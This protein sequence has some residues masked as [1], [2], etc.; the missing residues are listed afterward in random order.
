MSRE[1]EII[2]ASINYTMK[3]RPNVLAGDK[4]SEEM[5]EFN[6]NKAF[7]EG[8]KWADEHPN[9]YNDEKYHTVK[10]SDLDRLYKKLEVYEKYF[11]IACAWLE[12][13]DTE[14]EY[15]YSEGEYTF[16]NTEKFIDDSRKAMED[17]I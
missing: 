8:A 7:E 2:E 6:R 1:K 4:F 9:L 5:R 14:M 16:F 15:L 10:V 13:R 3:N 11:D 17:K 12:G